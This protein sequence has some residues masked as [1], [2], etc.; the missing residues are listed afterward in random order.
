MNR[1]FIILLLFTLAS[2]DILAQTLIPFLSKNGKFGLADERGKIVIEPQFDDNIEP[3]FP[4]T[5]SI[6]CKKNG[7]MVRV[8]PNGLVIPNPR[9]IMHRTIPVHN[10]GR[11]NDM[12]DSITHLLAFQVG[13]KWQI[14]DLK[15]GGKMVET[16]QEDYLSLPEW[17]KINTHILTG[18][19]E[20]RFRYGAMRIFHAD[21]SVNFLDENL[22]EILPKY[23][24]AAAIVDANYFIFAESKDHFGV[25]NRNGKTVVAPVFRS[26]ESCDKTGF[27]IANKPRDGSNGRKGSCGLVN[28]DGKIV[29]DTV[30]SDIEQVSGTDL[31][32]V[33]NMGK[34]G[35]FDFDG[36][37]IIP[38]EAEYAYKQ[39]FGFTIIRWPN[40]EGMNLIDRH[41]KRL[42]EK[43]VA[44]V[45][46]IP[47]PEKLFFKVKSGGW[48]SILDTSMTVLARD[49]VENLDLLEVDP[50]L[51]LVR[52]HSSTSSS[53]YS[54][55]RTVMI[56]NGAGKIWAEGKF[57]AV[58]NIK[59]LPDDLRMVYL[60]RLKG[61]VNSNW[62]EILP[63]V[64]EEIMAEYLREDT[65]IWVKKKGDILFSA[66][67]KR[68]KKRTDITDAPEPNRESALRVIAQIQS[69]STGG[70]MATLFDGSQIKWPDS[71]QN[72][73]VLASFRSKTG[74]A[75]VVGFTSKRMTTV[76]DHRFSN[77]LPTGYGIPE[78]TA[79]ELVLDRFT[80]YGL[81]V[82]KKIRD[83][84]PIKPSAAQPKSE[85]IEPAREAPNVKELDSPVE[86]LMG[87]GVGAGNPTRKT[88]PIFDET[89]GVIDWEG[90]WVLQPKINVEYLVLSPF[91]VGEF[92]IGA[93]SSSHEFFE[94]GL[95][96]H[97]VQQTEKGVFE[98][99]WLALDRFSIKDRNNMKIGRVRAGSQR[100]AE[101]AYFD[102]KG[103][104][105]TDWIFENGPDFLSAKNLVH[106]WEKD[107]LKS[108][109]AVIDAN[110]KT[111]FEFGN[112]MTDD[113][114][115]KWSKQDMTYMTVKECKVGENMPMGLMDSTGRLVLPLKYFDLQIWENDR[116]L[117]AK[118]TDS[119]S[120][121]MTLEGKIIHE[122]APS[123]SGVSM[124]YNGRG[125]KR[126]HIGPI[127][128]WT[129]KETI[130]I[131]DKGKVLRRFDLPFARH[132]L[133]NNSADRYVVLM[134]DKQKVWA[135]F[136]SGQLFFE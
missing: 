119:R 124:Q 42:L 26:L 92:P 113:P 4:K 14:I 66:F 54:S 100:M 31:L 99:N 76:L 2:Q 114:P 19:S 84:K 45:S 69:V 6:D 109:Q 72:Q 104:P 70:K 5:L 16:Y 133:D 24:A 135:D 81:L 57:D 126:V 115:R 93:K 108:R 10:Y 39:N 63:P 17:A 121:L 123:K 116:F 90:N 46:I 102:Q 65:L 112:T 61:V 36:R 64:F 68:G 136:L 131:D 18:G 58:S 32:I 75:V 88:E 28:A 74:G 122:F 59:N 55:D 97:R 105:I 111:L 25:A 132:L 29:L 21:G 110:G 20:F 35:V 9:L 12:I 98:A 125:A 101:Y 78:Y 51:F 130:L 106:I 96:L 60:N 134:K 86:Y 62:A 23:A 71:L 15:A 38:I 89:Y 120:V 85:P 33:K 91:L 82:V 117:T 95:R 43:N 103:K 37:E 79:S 13:Q 41:G 94:K 118:T 67:D 52:K 87:Q 7:E 48:T 1:F 73:R 107:V 50:L 127:A 128:A 40:K 47:F 80:Q 3:F 22:R 77:I 11:N 44:E 83:E 27:F 53:E 49:S 30:F 34:S 8:F 129:E 56:R